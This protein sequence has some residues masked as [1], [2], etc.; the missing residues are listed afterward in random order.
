MGGLLTRIPAYEFSYW[1]AASDTDEL[2]QEIFV[3][4]LHGH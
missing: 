2:L 1:G 3:G 4:W